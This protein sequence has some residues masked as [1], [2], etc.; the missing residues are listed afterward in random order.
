MPIS[1]SI[2]VFNLV[3]SLT[4]AEKRNFRQYATRIQANEDLLFLNLFDLLDK[5]KEF[6]EKNILKNMGG[7]SKTQFSNTKRHLYSQLIASLRM[8]YKEKRANFK[9][10]E[11]IDYAYILYGKGLYLQALKILQKAKNIA[12]KHHLNYMQLTISE[13]EKKIET[14]HIT[15][16]GSSK[17]Q[18][19]I[20]E[21]ERIQKHTNHLIQLSN[22]RIRMHAKYLEH[23]H[24]RSQKEAM[25]IKTY[26][27]LQVAHLHLD[28]LGLV[29]QIYYVQACVWYNFILLDFHS[30]L[31]YAVQWIELLESNPALIEKDVDLFMRGFHYV[32]TTTYHLKDRDK[33]SKY[34]DKFESFRKSNYGKFN[35]NSQ[36]LSF[37]YVHTGRLDKIILTSDF[38][39]AEAVIHK[40]INRLKRYKYRLDNH[41][42]MVFYFKFAWIYLCIDKTT[43]SIDYLNKIINNELHKL[44]EDIQNYARVLHLM[45][46]YEAENYTILDYLLKTHSNYFNRKKGLNEFL[47]LALNMFK[48]L[49][50]KGLLD[51]KKIFKKYLS[52]FKQINKDPYASKALVYLDIIT[53]INS[54]IKNQNLKSIL[55]KQ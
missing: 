12:Q 11:Y 35:Q 51:H 31:K 25:E 48:E 18:E 27:H 7:I 39:K 8:L 44:R 10:R 9:V 42:I 14:R 38:S 6:D 1:K 23:G 5:Q 47:I 37:L 28:K 49:K 3:K 50:G 55:K 17:A 32:L 30:C 19:L 36:I 41:R 16:S 29:E 21:S 20:D 24:V 2:D 46:H 22:L 52:L 53:W 13:F 40:S 15:R 45:C 4:S 34:L 54:K 26:Y 33:H 43:K